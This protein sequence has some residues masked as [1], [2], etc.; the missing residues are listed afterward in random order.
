MNPSKDQTGKY[1]QSDREVELRRSQRRLHGALVF[2][3][4]LSVFLL[5]GLIG[6]GLN[7]RD[8]VHGLSEELS[9]FKAN[10]TEERNLLNSSLA[11]MNKKLQQLQS[12]SAQNK[13]CPTGWRMFSCT[14]YFISNTTDSW[15]KG[16]Q[17]CRDRGGDL[18]VIDSPEE[19]EF[20]NK[21]AKNA[22]IGLSDKEKEGTWKWTDGT[23]LTLTYWR[24]NQPDNGGGDPQWGEEDCAHMTPTN[25]WNDLSCDAS[26]RWICRMGFV[27]G[28]VHSSTLLSFW[29]LLHNLLESH[30]HHCTTGVTMRTLLLASA[31]IAGL[32]VSSS[33]IPKPYNAYCSSLWLFSSPC[34]EISTKLVQQIEAFSPVNGCDECRYMLVS[35]SPLTIKANHT[36][37]DGLQAENISFTLHPTILA[38]G[39]RVSGFSV[40]QSFTSLLDGSLNYCN[41]YNLLAGSGLTSDPGFKEMT[42]EWTCP[43]Y[44]L[45]TCDSK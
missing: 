40:S 29:V 43:G 26:L 10:L 45:S 42:S 6:L 11:E 32:F 3:G 28:S 25:E 31:L 37:L 30:R 33:A 19:Q 38:S 5:A 27:V 16:R 36:S 7:Y 18:V 17:D 14:C 2:L 4:L 44:G 34:A 22:W 20:L 12:L 15:E 41:L 24:T 21:I 8:S 23:P 1:V 13:T 35:A 39:C 9:A